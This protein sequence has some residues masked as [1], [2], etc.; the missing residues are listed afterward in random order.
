MYVPFKAIFTAL[1]VAATWNNTT[2]A[3]TANKTNFTLTMTANAK[4]A[5][6][7]GKTISLATPVKI[8]NGTTYV[9]LRF[10]GQSLDAT[11]EYKA[12]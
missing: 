10:V 7:N 12:K 4:T 9:P 2:K 1:N 5:K 8:I 3:V 6:L 11:I